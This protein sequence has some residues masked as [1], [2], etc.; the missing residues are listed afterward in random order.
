L[1]ELVGEIADEYNPDEPE[2]VAVS[3]GV[4][5]V[6]GATPIHDLNEKL[7]VNLPDNEWDTV[8]GLVLGLLGAIP[9]GPGDPLREPGV[10]RRAGGSGGGR[11]GPPRKSRSR[12]RADPPL[13]GVSRAASAPRFGQHLAREALEPGEPA[14]CRHDHVLDAPLAFAPLQLLGALLGGADERQ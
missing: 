2:I 5:R 6:D 4:Y 8:G 3:E 1:E 11:G 9:R 7:G 13:P 10:P 12:R 14:G